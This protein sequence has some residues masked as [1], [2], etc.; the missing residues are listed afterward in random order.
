MP[1]KTFRRFSERVRYFDADLE[2]SAVLA[3]QFLVTP[4][5]NQTVAAALGVDGSRYTHLGSRKNSLRSRE[6]L[7]NHL[8]NTIYSGFIKDIYEEFSEFLSTTLSRAALKGINPERFVGDSKL[9]IQASAILSLRSWDEVV[10]MISDRIFRK[11]E[12]EKST[13]SLVSKVGAKLG[14]DIDPQI[15]GD[16]MPYLEA[17]HILVHRNGLT[18]D[19]YRNRYPNIPRNYG[20]LILNDEFASNALAN[21]RALAKHIDDQIIASDLV[22]P[23]HLEG[24]A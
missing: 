4:N 11:I 16:A 12:N 1:T 5:S 3:E 8:I 20:R 21:I 6:I 19:S 2:L 17:R 9:D 7:G 15:V 10:G 14:L 18:D 24:A 22:R 13:I 23:E